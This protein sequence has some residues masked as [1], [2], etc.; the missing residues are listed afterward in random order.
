MSPPPAKPPGAGLTPHQTAVDAELRRLRA[1]LR[2]LRVTPPASVPPSPAVLRPGLA[3]AVLR[4]WTTAAN[5][6]DATLAAVLRFP[7]D[8]VEQLRA[9]GVPAAKLGKRGLFGVVDVLERWASDPAVRFARY[10]PTRL[11]A[12]R[13][14]NKLIGYL[15]QHV[16]I[17][18][19]EVR[20]RLML[21]A[22]LAAGAVDELVR[23]GKA[24]LR[25]GRGTNVAVPKGR[26]GPPRQ[27]INVETWDGT[28]WLG[29]WDTIWAAEHLPDG[30]TERW[31]W[32]WAQRAEMK[33]AEPDSS[34][35][36]DEARRLR[37][38]KAVRWTDAETGELVTADPA[39]IFPTAADES[40]AL[41]VGR[42]ERARAVPVSRISTGAGLIYDV[43][44]DMPWLEAI[45][46]LLKD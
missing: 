10:S 33:K 27:G 42:L 40:K 43:R 32:H 41:L 2:E 21:S 1:T 8:L 44:L 39:R 36:R 18:H 9:I 25:N 20:A 17:S 29:F 34:Q 7:G 12:V 23:T 15:V 38:A 13:R 28:R 5:G 19:E 22:A 37:E 31:G 30:A 45:Y 14:R 24:V 4:R 6:I 46:D 11:A 3:G 26:L 16:L 35:L